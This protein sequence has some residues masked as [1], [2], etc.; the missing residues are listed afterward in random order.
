MAIVVSQTAALG[1]K[2]YLQLVQRL[3]QECGVLGS[4]PAALANQVA[5]INRLSKWIN[6]AWIDIQEMHDDWFFLR[7]NF[8]FKTVANTQAYS[9]SAAGLLTPLG[10]WKRDSFR[11]YSPSLGVSNEM[12]VPFV[13]YET[14]RNQ[15]QYGSM[16]T[17]Y[18]RPTVFSIDPPKNIVLGAIP[19]TVYTVVG[20]YYTAPTELVSD[21]DVP[22]LP[23]RYHMAIV[24]RAMIHYGLYE[25]ASEVLSRGTA[26]FEKMMTRLMADQLPDVTFGA[27]L[28]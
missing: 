14:F 22:I 18:T 12:I 27:P 2:T 19:D 25:A 26:E 17:T 21:S 28:A 23:A 24:Y 7:N 13:D 5:D 9:E 4:D 1:S 15:F 6:A 11:I 3:R 8:S 10:N 16:R 20:E